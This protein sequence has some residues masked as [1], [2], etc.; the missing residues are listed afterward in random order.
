LLQP[1]FSIKV[2][3]VLNS[4]LITFE[5]SG[6]LYFVS[7]YDK[8]IRYITCHTPNEIRRRIYMVE[9]EAIL[10]MNSVNFSRE[11]GLR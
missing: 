10:F 4:A 9:I 2:E 6:L 1:K 8:I 3:L 5:G 11:K 7:R